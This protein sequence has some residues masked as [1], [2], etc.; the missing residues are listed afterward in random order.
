MK[1]YKKNQKQHYISLQYGGIRL[2]NKSFH[3][4]S[5]VLYT[6]NSVL[7]H[8]NIPSEIVKLCD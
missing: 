2:N 4:E 3:T 8:N 7:L 1:D 5:K 6:W